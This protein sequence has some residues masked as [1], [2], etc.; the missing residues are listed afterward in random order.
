MPLPSASPAPVPA[1]V[2]PSGPY[3]LRLLDTF[4]AH[5]EAAIELGRLAAQRGIGDDLLR[6]AREI[7]LAHRSEMAQLR[8]LRRRWLGAASV[9]RDPS[10]PGAY[11]INATDL[12]ELRAHERGEALDHLLLR[13]L[14]NLHQ[15]GVMLARDGAQ[16]A[17]HAPLRDLALESSAR[18]LH[19][20]TALEKLGAPGEHTA[21]E[22]AHRDQ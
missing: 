15:R 21:A 5:D 16:N 22:H 14:V 11:V 18:E 13:N 3:D 7:V 9:H 12:A 8:A 19:L 2:R 20:A 10:L 6:T 4:I 17:T 1:E